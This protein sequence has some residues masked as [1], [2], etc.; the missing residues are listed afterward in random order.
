ETTAATAVAAGTTGAPATRAAP[1]SRVTRATAE[2][3]A[4]GIATTAPGASPVRF[5][6][7]PLH[8]FL[9]HLGEEARGRVVHR[10]TPAGA[11]DR[12]ADVRLLLRAG[13]AHVRQATLLG[14]LGGV[15]ERTHV[16]KLAVLPAG[17]ED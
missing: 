5:L 7:E 9:G 11:G 8:Q 15:A 10:C 1:A 2:A 14:E 12:A 13:N 3:G 6:A 16:R 17:E 4:I